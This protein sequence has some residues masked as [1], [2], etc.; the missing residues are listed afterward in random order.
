[1]LRGAYPQDVQVFDRIMKVNG[2]GGSSRKLLQLLESHGGCWF[3]LGGEL[4]GVVTAKGEEASEINT[5]SLSLSIDIY[6]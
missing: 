6:G 2:S 4:V 3:R 5:H 1:M